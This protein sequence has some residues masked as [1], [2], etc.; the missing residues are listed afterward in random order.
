MH[1]AGPAELGLHTAMCLE[2]NRL[3]M[4]VLYYN[5][6]FYDDIFSHKKMRRK[7]FYSRQE[8]RISQRRQFF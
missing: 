4:S 2:F 1:N 5:I 3:N 8:F 7:I 6:M